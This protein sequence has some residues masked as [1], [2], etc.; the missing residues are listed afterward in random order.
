MPLESRDS[1]ELCKVRN[2]PTLHCGYYADLVS[3]G[4]RSFT[5]LSAGGAGRYCRK[6]PPQGW[7]APRRDWASKAQPSDCFTRSG[8]IG[9]CR[10]R[11]PMS[12]A[13]ALA[14]AGATAGTPASPIPVGGSL[15]E[16]TAT[17]I[18]GM[19]DMRNTG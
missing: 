8:V 12:C 6:I 16:I 14:I 13:T 7:K 18:G 17:S 10:R 4:R 19:S 3:R 9:K 11:L 15:V 5:A 2:A 1:W